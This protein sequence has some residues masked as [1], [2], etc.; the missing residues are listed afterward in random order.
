[1]ADYDYSADTSKQAALMREV[2][3]AVEEQ[4]A[5]AKYQQNLSDGQDRRDACHAR[6]RD[7]QV[8]LLKDAAVPALPW[9]NG[10]HLIGADGKKQDAGSWT[11][12]VRVNVAPSE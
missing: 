8:T 3:K 2:A 7:L 1:M 4:D 6:I 12:R 11:G 10:V 9:T 5:C